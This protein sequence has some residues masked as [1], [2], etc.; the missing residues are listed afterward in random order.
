MGLERGR[1]GGTGVSGVTATLAAA[2]RPARA[3]SSATVTV[4]A[5]QTW[6]GTGIA[7]SAGEEV[8]VS[9]TG[10]IDYGP[11]NTPSSPAGY[12]FS[13]RV[14]RGGTCG[15]DAYAPGA[16][17]FPAPGVNCWS[18]LFRIGA[19]GVPFPAGTKIS[20]TSPVSGELYLG[21]NDNAVSDNRGSW[22]AT[23]TTG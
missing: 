2:S 10:T 20:F 16:A 21:I 9:A 23:I 22:T 15:T 5:D 4:P 1:L 14:P 13:Q 6:T 18:M 8:M 19:S 11:G 3:S 7:L 17:P 12:R